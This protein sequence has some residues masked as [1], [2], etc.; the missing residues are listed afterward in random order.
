[1]Q[2]SQLFLQHHVSLDAAMLPNMM[3]IDWNSETVSQAQLDVCLYKSC[4][5]YGVSLEQWNTKTGIYVW[6]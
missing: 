6:D 1:M 4:F 5:G 2:D 3:I